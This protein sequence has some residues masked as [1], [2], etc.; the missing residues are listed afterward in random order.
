[1]RNILFFMPIL[2]MMACSAT[3]SLDE[4]EKDSERGGSEKNASSK[5]METG[6]LPFAIEGMDTISYYYSPVS[7]YSNKALVDSLQKKYGDAAGDMIVVY[8]SAEYCRVVSEEGGTGRVSVIHTQ[9]FTEWPYL[10]L[11]RGDSLLYTQPESCSPLT[12][13]GCRR[14]ALGYMK[15]VVTEDDVFYYARTQSEELIVQIKDSV[16]YS[17]YN[18]DSD[19]VNPNQWTKWDKKVFEKDTLVKFIGDDTLFIE[20]YNVKITDEGDTWVFENET[21]SSRDD[22]DESEFENMK[23]EEFCV[24]FERL[25]ND[26]IACIQRNMGVPSDVYPRLCR[27]ANISYSDKVWCILDKDDLLN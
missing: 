4:F 12:W 10:L 8:D 13:N 25:F 9:E 19:Y 20:K 16:I 23:T 21:C 3:D 17:W 22:R 14:D 24:F 6:G 26:A 11:T 5:N 1:M 2:L 27:D 7:A 15:K 18:D